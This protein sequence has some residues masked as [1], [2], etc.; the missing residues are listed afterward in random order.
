MASS[1]GCSPYALSV[2]FL[3]GIFIGRED[4]PEADQVFN[5]GGSAGHTAW[6]GWS[7]QLQQE[8]LGAPP[9]PLQYRI[10]STIIADQLHAIAKAE[11][12]RL[13]QLQDE[14]RAAFSQ[15]TFGRS[16]AD[17]VGRRL[18]LVRSPDDLVDLAA[19]LNLLLTK[20]ERKDD[21]WQGHGRD[22]PMYLRPDSVFGVF[23]RRLKAALDGS[24]FSRLSAIY[25]E[26]VRYSASLRARPALGVE[27][28]SGL[29]V[30]ASFE[31][32]VMMDLG[33]PPTVG[34]PSFGGSEGV[35][36]GGGHIDAF[37]RQQGAAGQGGASEE[38]IDG[39]VDGGSGLDGERRFPREVSAWQLQWRL[40]RKVLR[41][42]DGLSSQVP[43][44]EIEGEV[45]SALGAWSDVPKAHF[46]R[47]MNCMHH[48][49]LQGSLD[50]LHRYFD[51]AVR[52]GGPSMSNAEG[53]LDLAKGAQGGSGRHT[54]QHAALALARLH[55]EFGHLE[56]ASLALGEAI[57][58]AQQSGDKA[59][60]AQAMGWLHQVLAAQGHPRAGDVLRRCASQAADLNLHQLMNSA[61]LLLA[62]E[63]AVA[64]HGNPTHGSSSGGG[65][66]GNGSN[67]NGTAMMGSS[68]GG[69]AR[70]KRASPTRVWECLA[71]VASGDLRGLLESEAANAGTGLSDNMPTSGAGGGGRPA[72]ELRGGTG[73]EVAA[74]LSCQR[75]L[76]EAGAFERFGYS[77]MAVACARSV[78]QVH[79]DLATASNV[80]LASACV[81]NAVLRGKRFPGLPESLHPQQHPPHGSKDAMDGV[82]ERKGEPDD[83]MEVAGEGDGR[84]E[85]GTGE[86]AC[87]FEVALSVALR[88]HKQFP[89]PVSNVWAA[90]V[91]V[92]LHEWM[93]NRGEFRA[94]EGLGMSLRGCCPLSRGAEAFIEAR[95]QRVRLLRAQ[96]RWSEAVNAASELVKLSDTRGL[97]PQYARLLLELS[98]ARLGAEPASPVGALP[99]ALRCLAVCE[100]YSLD[101]IHASAMT[102]LAEVHLRMGSTRRARILLK[103]C[104]GQLLANA[105]VQAQGEAWLAMAKCEMAEVSL[106]DPCSAASKASPSS[107][108]GGVVDGGREGGRAGAGAGVGMAGTTRRDEALKR[109]VLH[110]NQAITMLKR[111]HDFAGL[112]ECFYLKARVCGK[113]VS[114]GSDSFDEAE[115][116]SERDASARDFL[117]VSKA[118]VRALG[119]QPN[120]I[121]KFRVGI[122]VDI[123]EL[124]HRSLGLLDSLELE[125]SSPS[126]VPTNVDSRSNLIGDEASPAAANASGLPPPTRTSFH[127]RSPSPQ[128]TVVVRPAL[129]LRSAAAGYGCTKTE[130]VGSGSSTASIEQ[131]RRPWSPATSPA[132]SMMKREGFA[133][134]DVAAT[135]GGGFYLERPL[136]SW[137][138]LQDHRG[139]AV[140]E[141]STNRAGDVGDEPQ[142]REYS[143]VGEFS[144]ASTPPRFASF[145]VGGVPQPE[146][147]VEAVVVTAPPAP[148]L[149]PGPTTEEKN[150]A[151]SEATAGKGSGVVGAITLKAVWNAGMDTSFLPAGVDPPPVWFAL[152]MAQASEAG[153]PTHGA[154]G[155]A[156]KV[157]RNPV[158]I[159]NGSLAFST[160]SA[161]SAAAAGSSSP[162]KST[163]SFGNAQEI[164]VRKD[165]GSGQ[166]WTLGSSS[167]G[168]PKTRGEGFRVVW[169]GEEPRAE[170]GLMEAFT[171]PL[172]P[173][174]RFAIRVRVECRFGVAVS[175]ATVYQTAVVAPLPPKGLRAILATHES[176]A[177]NTSRCVRL[178]WDPFQPGHGKN[179]V[180]SFTVQIG[181][182][183]PT[184]LGVPHIIAEYR[185]RA[186]GP[187][188]RGPWSESLPVDMF[189]PVVEGSAKPFNMPSGD[190]KGG[191]GGGGSVTVS[192]V[193]CIS[194]EDKGT[195][196]RQPMDFFRP[197]T[198][199]RDPL[200]GE[201]RRLWTK[202][203]PLRVSSP[204]PAVA[205]LVLPG[206]V[207]TARTI[208][209]AEHKHRRAGGSNQLLWGAL[210]SPRAARGCRMAATLTSSG[211]APEE[212]ETPALAPSDDIN[213]DIRG[214]AAVDGGNP[215]KLQGT[216]VAG[217]AL[218][219]TSR[220]GGDCTA[221][222]AVP[223]YL[224]M[225]LREE[226]DVSW[227]LG[228][229]AVGRRDG[230][231]EGGEGC[232]GR[233][234]GGDGASTGLSGTDE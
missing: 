57:R 201:A 89:H 176:R 68:M 107:E 10:L 229:S 70:R 88:Q 168:K 110:L 129:R 130:P 39:G 13:D 159:Q 142:C 98:R 119:L 227:R 20:P 154:G 9:G 120:T 198:R 90:G 21:T 99:H 114:E 96:A 219:P 222:A 163:R 192:S 87:V 29:S 16:V 105:P 171:P 144:T 132:M 230:R 125:A 37:L 72:V 113:M 77:D 15:S 220:D 30:D 36:R 191:D 124:R 136:L 143:A 12:K 200:T 59:C 41:L 117:A 203:R 204:P 109:V 186:E 214:R 207:V 52:R 23:V 121:V 162:T 35:G 184:T 211:M 199:A 50:S 197:G 131:L 225:M 75:L 33:S 6:N 140:W 116:T 233:K 66:G 126:G 78:L 218:P 5:G 79:G 64:Q 135:V 7:E 111:C 169:T 83:D 193:T 3:I 101:A 73:G 213:H 4:N 94:A 2:G 14:V 55:F 1:E 177:G 134:H 221:E 180:T 82:Q 195:S 34:R 152:E 128:R 137:G 95:L 97:A 11:I 49:E 56:L 167:W 32:D 185:V 231:I 45:Q 149:E 170:G 48:R 210:A 223:P 71:A 24:S 22:R 100:S 166:C 215:Y 28:P 102:H 108:S 53:F 174:M 81:M 153:P 44:E 139:G 18:L 122:D 234:P 146:T 74:G 196:S 224:A 216:T 226:M 189:V 194:S 65:D 62:K 115:A 209:A 208:A 26:V 206:A 93:V 190:V 172:P 157:A 104:L 112:R 17:R 150:E 155:T 138:R 145:V 232:G 182:L 38:K 160:P 51:Y 47:L 188:G 86:C 118:G 123:T 156:T 58:V 133:V 205:A 46:L 54:P 31:D 148:I 181:C 178:L 202:Q 165:I 60:V 8:P 228:C 212:T 85:R 25:E 69:G 187:G 91:M 217:E 27:S 175:A 147:A 92:L 141:S 179:V 127:Q 158:S 173:G 103:A 161:R 63:A 43:F 40:Q 80:E 84:G 76:V 164:P 183:D 106:Q 42:E 19:N 61:T 151:S 67:S